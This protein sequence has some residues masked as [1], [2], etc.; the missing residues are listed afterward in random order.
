MTRFC[1]LVETSAPSEYSGRA[2]RPSLMA[3]AIFVI[4]STTVSYSDS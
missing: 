3:A 2:Q 1:W 4:P